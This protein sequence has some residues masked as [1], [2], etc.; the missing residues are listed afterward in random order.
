M[1]LHVVLNEP[2]LGCG[3]GSR[4]WRGSGAKVAE[5]VDLVARDGGDEDVF[6]L[7]ISVEQWGLEVVH[8]GHAFSNI[9]EDVQDLGLRQTVL[10]ACVH[11]V[12]QTSARAVLHEQ[13]DLVATSL[14]L[15]GVRV[16]VGDYL[17]VA[18]E[19]L[20]RLHLCP[21]VGQRLLV[22]HGDSLEHSDLGRAAIRPGDADQV[23]VG[24]TTLGQV[25]LNGDA[26]VAHLDLGAWRKGAGR[27]I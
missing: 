24:E 3:G 9:R 18:L 23:D 26:L 10:Q 21:H 2:T 19:L 27:G 7:E 8:G 13:K 20:H 25:L 14:E 22:W 16:H 4:P 6:D 5:L 12:N 1:A 11:E 17:L 15:R